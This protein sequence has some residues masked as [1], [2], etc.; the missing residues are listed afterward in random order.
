MTKHETETEFRRE[1]K[2]LLAKY[3]AELDAKDHYVGY[4]ECGED[5]RMTVTIDG[6]WD[7]D[8]EVI[9]EYQSFNLG[10]FIDGKD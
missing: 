5:I 4:P 2:A 7:K 10:T 6:K 3:D 8:G 1:L 9:Q